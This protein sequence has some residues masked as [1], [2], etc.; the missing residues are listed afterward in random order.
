MPPAVDSDSAITA[1]F[2]ESHVIGSDTTSTSNFIFHG[3]TSNVSQIGLSSDIDLAGDIM[4]WTYF[5]CWVCAFYPQIIVNFTRRSITGLNLDF[6]ALNFAGYLAYSSF[7]AG[8]F[9]IPE[10]Q[11]EYFQ[12]HPGGVIPVQLNDVLFT[13]H[14]LMAVSI[15]IAQALSFERAGQELSSVCIG[16]ILISGAYTIVCLTLSIIGIFT[17]LTF[18]YYFSY[19]KLFTSVIKYFPQVY[20]LY[21]RKSTDGFSTFGVLL[22]L[23]GGIASIL[24]MILIA[25]NYHD[26]GSVTGDPTKLGLGIISIAYCFI[27]IF[28]RLF[29]GTEYQPL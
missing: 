6:I 26:W 22:D 25:Y 4:G 18:I 5:V 13:F 27:L 15:W 28:E 2:H 12:L 29:Y 21:K 8:L 10:L 23:T 17:W 1:L 19:I 3:D 7:N 20:H 11:K 24:Q 16:V 9:W 14:N